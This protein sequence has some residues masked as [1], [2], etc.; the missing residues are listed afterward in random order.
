MMKKTILSIMAML[1]LGLQG[2][3]DVS[4]INV[5]YCNGEVSTSGNIA[6]SEKD[7]WISAAIYIPAGTIAT[8]GGNSIDSIRAGLASKLNVDTLAVWVRSELDGDNIA[9]GRITTDSEVKIAK[10]WNVVGLETPY[11]IPE[12][13]SGGLYIG[14]S[15]HQKGASF[16]LSTLSVPTPGGLYVKMPGE[17]WADRG[18]EGT[19][20]V[21]G[22]VYGDRLPS[23]NLALTDVSLQKRYA[24]QKG[25]LTVSGSVKNLATVTVSGFDV[26]VDAE[27]GTGPCAAHVD[28]NLAYNETMD[29]SVTVEPGITDEGDGV[30]EA[31]VTIGNIA[32]GA[33]EDPSDNMLSG[34]FEVVTHDFTRNIIV[35]EFTTEQCPNCPRV[36]AYINGALESGQYDGRVFVAC[37]HSGYYTD[38][39]TASFATDYLWFYNAGGST[40][41]PAMMIDRYNFSG[42]TPVMCPTSQGE[43]EA[44]WSARL[45]EPAY[46]SMEVEAAVDEADNNKVRVTV[47][48]AKSI[49]AIC[50]NPRI[51]VY[52]LE[53]A[54]SA[55]SQAGA[56][57]SFT[58]NHVVRACN[59]TWGDA[60]E[61]TGDDYVYSCEFVLSSQWVRDNLQAVAFIYNYDDEDATACEV[62][63]AGGIRYADF[64]NAVADGIT[65]AEADA[66]EAAAYYTLSGDRVAEGSL[67]SGIYIVKSAG[68][69]RKVVVK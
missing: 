8:Y 14:Y 49:D 61:W 56:S 38:W 31:T 63:N 54:I 22:L 11:D 29:F 27:G 12:D 39:L 60:I 41:A 21:E 26:I 58:H 62:A 66:T 7:V 18:S 15:F 59:S 4:G 34:S 32:E 37:H 17:E 2:Y 50:D 1:S 30:S 43:M 16:G 19:L 13:G 40:Y 64:E 48:G 55:R 45:A 42:S 10:G 9:E 68:K 25:T 52:L 6:S 47:S 3:A 36:A 57:G 69:C 23:V 33:D 24:I 44:Y 28:A 51:T 20:C 46:V 5:G 65:A 53:D 35:E 67:R